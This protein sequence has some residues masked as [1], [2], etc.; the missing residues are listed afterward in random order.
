[1]VVSL[2]REAEAETEWWLMG[3]NSNSFAEVNKIY[4][5]NQ[6]SRT[7]NLQFHHSISKLIFAISQ[8]A[9]NMGREVISKLV[10]IFEAVAVFFVADE[11]NFRES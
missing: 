11:F 6:R 3:A 8:I 7:I 4:A 2:P 10:R 1:L 9:P 5:R